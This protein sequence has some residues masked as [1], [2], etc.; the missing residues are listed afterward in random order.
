[1]SIFEAVIRANTGP[2]NGAGQFRDV[3]MWTNILKLKYVLALLDCGK[4]IS[5]RRH[6]TLG[7]CENIFKVSIKFSNWF[8]NRRGP[9]WEL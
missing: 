6:T 5:E 8:H 1:M 2:H 4:I 3:L 9:K 7:N